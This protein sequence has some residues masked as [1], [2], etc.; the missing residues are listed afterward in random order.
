M[1]TE[2]IYIGNQRVKITNAPVEGDFIKIN[3][4]TFY[5]IS[6]FDKMPPF[7]IS[8]V[9]ATDHWMYISSKG[10]LTAGRRNADNA[11]FAYSNDDILHDVYEITGSKTIIKIADKGKLYLWEPF[12]EN[13]SG[14]YSVTRNLNKNISSTEIIFEEIN[15]D[16]EIKFQY[17]WTC[18][19]KYGFVKTSKILNEAKSK[20]KIEILDGIQ[21]IL[22][23]GVQQKLQSGFSTLVDGYKKSEL[24]PEHGLG[25]FSLSSI[26]SDS[27]QPAESLLAATVWTTGINVEKYL[28]CSRQI[29]NFRRNIPI[30]PEENI[31]GTRGSF[32]VNSSLQIKPKSSA[33][34]Y[35]VA[36]VNQNSGD[37][38][39]LIN[40]IKGKEAYGLVLH[41]IEESKLMLSKIVA[42]ADG[43][44]L[45]G[46]K[47]NSARHFSNVLF[48]I[49]RGGIFDDSYNV[50]KKDFISFVEKANPFVI[51]AHKSFLEKLEDKISIA[52][53]RNKVSNLG[54]PHFTKLA[55]EYLPLT[56]SR[57][58][59]DP[60]RPWNSF[61]IDVKNIHNE[62]ILNYQGNWRDIFQNWEALALSYPKFLESMITKFLNTSTADGYN[63][64][65]VFRDGFDWEEQEPHNPWAN[66]GYW[67]DHQIIYLLKLLELFKDFNP[68]SLE[69][70]LNTEIF[71][72]ANVPYRIKDYQDILRDPRNTIEFDY[73]LDRKLKT[74]E[75]HYGTD[76]KFLKKSDHSL[77]QVNLVEKLLLTLLV[78]MSN[79]IPGGGIW[80]NT[81]RPE[82]NDAKN[83][84]VGNGVSMVTLFYIRRYVNFLKELLNDKSKEK[85]EIS[86][87]ITQL[88]NGINTVLFEITKIKKDSI[89]DKERKSFVNQ[90]GVVGSNYRRNIYEKGFDGKK[91]EISS[92]MITEFCKIC[93]AVIDNTIDENRRNDGLYHSY[94]ILLITRDEIKITHLYEMLEGQV[95]VLSSG[96]LS[97]QEA[98]ELLNSLKKS[99]LYRKDQN[100]Y[101]LYP[102][103]KL[104]AFIDKNNIPVELINK[105]KLLRSLLSSANKKI[106][107]KDEVGGI[108]FQSDIINSDQLKKKLEVLKDLKNKDYAEIEL[109]LVLDIYEKTFCHN[110]F[111][112]R[113]NTFYKYEGLGSIYWHMVSKLL[114]AV[115]EVYFYAE[116]Q[117][118]T[119]NELK[120]LK[121]FYYDIKSGIGTD[122]QPAQYG[123]F[124]TDPYSHTPFFAGA[125]QPGMTGQVKEDIISRFREIGIKIGDGKIIINPSLLRKEEF[126][127]K[128]E[129]FIYYDLDGKEQKINCKKNSFAMTYCQ[130]PFV[131]NLSNTEKIVVHKT[132]GE[133]VILDKLELK[134]EVSQS[135]FNRNGEIIGVEVFLDS[136]NFN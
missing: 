117:S 33:S 106:I 105:S 96:Y 90:L 6:N 35:I 108:H 85:F 54:D 32:L 36:E 58:H 123:A 15:H 71:T 49:M 135:I 17:S 115:Q 109:A 131:Y 129:T 4:E 29:S 27:A 88:F 79:F 101:M 61:S 19:E 13:Y 118:A 41:D 2:Q 77:V 28:L 136:H 133:E 122:K 5:R 97:T 92:E 72:F 91:H 134:E 64:Y 39:N 116:E 38:S 66:I 59:G 14:I 111:T 125:Q 74:D 94:N 47:L 110:E 60:S 52:E 7:L 44:Q 102:N 12:S 113:A 20:K 16:L 51:N 112:G 120:K 130:V 56:F 104:P 103:K 37:L 21:N 25:V 34:W 99:R 65:R 126:L 63:P 24:I 80:M 57:R 11:L 8:I 18:S 55:I 114:L 107:Y 26:P 62:K 1:N 124:P 69:K 100:S 81:Q 46:N 10:G 43:L 9:S 75:K 73:E 93:L 67:G 42:Q 23:S 127:K 83:A 45:T 121:D 84:L 22:P 132:N 31:N 128:E 82:W 30:E 76:T 87:E 86:K 68:N 78:K 48:N 119:K 70:L 3:N 50:E 95:A 98:I 40:T 53:L 89:G